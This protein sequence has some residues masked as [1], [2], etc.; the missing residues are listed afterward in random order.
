[1]FFASVTQYLIL[2]VWNARLLDI[3]HFM[4][5]SQLYELSHGDLETT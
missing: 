2:L 3:Y 1:M 5:L 4:R